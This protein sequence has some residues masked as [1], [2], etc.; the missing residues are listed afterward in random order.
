[1]SYISKKCANLL[2]KYSQ[3]INLTVDNLVKQADQLQ[4]ATQ[5]LVSQLATNSAAATGR[6][7]AADI[8]TLSKLDNDVS[9]L[10][11][12]ITT[13]YPQYR[14]NTKL[15]NAFNMANQAYSLITKLVRMFNVKK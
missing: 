12:N 5:H 4:R 15:M 9:N 8:Q 2:E 10:I 3:E 13:T 1:M 11:K 6:I 14:Q 7:E